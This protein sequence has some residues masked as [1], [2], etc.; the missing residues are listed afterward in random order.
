MTFGEEYLTHLRVIQHI[1]MASIEPIRY[2]GMDIVP[3]QFLKAVLPN[4]QDLGKNYE[5]ETSIGCRIRGLKKNSINGDLSGHLGFLSCD[6][7]FRA[8]CDQKNASTPSSR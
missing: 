1:G 6:E 4:P 2:N 8:H 7:C 3:L 5:G